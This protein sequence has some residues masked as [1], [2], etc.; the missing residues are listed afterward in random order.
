MAG[1]AIRFDPECDKAAELLGGYATIDD[2]L[3]VYLEPLYRK[4]DGFDTIQCAWGSVRYIKTEP[5]GAAPALIWYFLLE[6]NGDV[7]MTY[8]ERYEPT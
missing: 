4:P 1:R 2:A 8:V 5:I 7:L 3:D 6:R